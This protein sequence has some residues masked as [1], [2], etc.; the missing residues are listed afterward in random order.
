MFASLLAGLVSGE[1]ID[2][3][4]RARRAAITYAICLSLAGFGLLF[5][6]G[7]LY[8]WAARHLG[9]IEASLI[10]GAV[11]LGLAL[12]VLVIH[13]LTASSKMRRAAEQRKSDFTKVGIATAIAVLPGLLRSKAGLGVLMV[14]AV[15]LLAYVIYRENTT[16]GP[17]PD[18]Q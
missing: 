5:F 17:G 2:A 12:I 14:P 15:A 6:I 9:P 1:T 3:A 11:F 8:L 4:R 7:A 16:P 13:K 18:T 10:F